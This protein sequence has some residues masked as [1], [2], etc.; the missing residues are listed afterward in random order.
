VPIVVVGGLRFGDR[1][2]SSHLKRTHCFLALGQRKLM[3]RTDI[4]LPSVLDGIRGRLHNLLRVPRREEEGGNHQ[5][6]KSKV[7][8]P[9]M[10]LSSKQ[11]CRIR[12]GRP[13]HLIN[14]YLLCRRTLQ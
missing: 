11:A 2:C 3:K 5:T 1:G 13:D 9:S 14:C 8:I 4:A 6:S 7:F 12:H 10:L